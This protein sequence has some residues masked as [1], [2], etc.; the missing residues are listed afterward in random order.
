MI[1]RETARII[2]LEKK[3]REARLELQEALAET[4]RGE[5]RD[6][7]FET[8]AGPTNLSG[9]FADKRD[10]FMVHNMGT[11]CPQ[12]T[13]W[14]DGFNGFYPHLASRAAVVVVSPD[15]P[16]RQ[17]EFAASRGWRF[18]MAS[19][20]DKSFAADMGFADA[21]GRMLPGVSVFRREGDRIVRVTASGFDAGETFSSPVWHLLAL[22]PEG[23]DGW[24]PKITYG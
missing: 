2:S 3:L 20:K 7:A 22:L 5:V 19:V 14:A 21:A 1:L 8:A 9:L 17:A 16:A 15:P 6:Y 13:M 24:R 18:P 4:V 23:V 12:C 10:L 11:T